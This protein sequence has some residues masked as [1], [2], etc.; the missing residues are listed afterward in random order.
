MGEV[1]ASQFVL[2]VLQSSQFPARN[3]GLA[4]PDARQNGVLHH[5]RVCG[6]SRALS[7]WCRSPHVTALADGLGVWTLSP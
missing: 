3:Q 1:A 7:G 6:G 2:L 4:R 5:A